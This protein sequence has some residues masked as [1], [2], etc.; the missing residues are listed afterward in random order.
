MKFSLKFKNFGSL[1]LKY[2]GF[3]STKMLNF[4]SNFKSGSMLEK[5][6]NRNQPFTFL[7]KLL[8]SS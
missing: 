8:K 4:V 1:N 2:Q 5:Y 3:F 6:N 7:L